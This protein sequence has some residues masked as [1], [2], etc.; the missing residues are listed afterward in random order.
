MIN[1]FISIQ[2][3]NNTCFNVY[4]AQWY[5][6]LTAN[7]IARV[8]ITCAELS[9]FNDF[10]K[11]QNMIE[12]QECSHIIYI[13]L[14]CSPAHNVLCVTCSKKSTRRNERRVFHYHLMRGWLQ[15]HSNTFGKTTVFN[16]CEVSR[17]VNTKNCFSRIRTHSFLIH[18]PQS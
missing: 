7:L 4:V 2:L 13:T 11:A 14:D 1:L 3:Y 16:I 5:K 10:L 6:S 8:Q 18:S 9:Y 12:I 15:L 17:H